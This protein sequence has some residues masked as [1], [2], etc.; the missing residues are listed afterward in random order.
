MHG[1]VESLFFFNHCKSLMFVTVEGYQ[2]NK[3]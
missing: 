1:L 2:K 3:N